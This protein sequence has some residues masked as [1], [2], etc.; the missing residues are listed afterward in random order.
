MTK[1]LIIPLVILLIFGIFLLFD[2]ID[3]RLSD[4]EEN[5]TAIDFLSSNFTY[6][7]NISL[8]FNQSRQPNTTRPVEV[9]PTTRIDC[10]LSAGAC[11][12]R[13]EYQISPDNVTWTIVGH[14]RLSEDIGGVLATLEYEEDEM[15]SFKVPIGNY[16]RL[17]AITEADAPTLS[18]RWLREIHL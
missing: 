15:A 10:P 1:T 12:A 2:S 11:V 18:I 5:I 7:G 3:S 16:Y 8:N 4:I 17:V 6:S 14:R 9:F 13:I